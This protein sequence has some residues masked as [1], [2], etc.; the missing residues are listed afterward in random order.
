M[1]LG[2]TAM[3]KKSV[4]VII[5]TNGPG[6]LSTWVKPVVDN[7]SK[8]NKLSKK[9]NKYYLSLNLVL[10]PCPNSTGKEY[11][12]AKSWMKFETVTKAENF[13]KLIIRPSLYAKWPKNGIVVFLGGDQFWSVLLSK[14]LGYANITYSEWVARWPRWCDIIATMNENVKKRIPQKYRYKCEV[15]GD[16]MADFKNSK[17]ISSNTREKQWIALLPGSKKAKLSV[18]IPYFLEVADNIAKKDK[19]INL[20]IPMAPTT[21]TNDYLF[22]QSNE[23]PIAKKYSSKIKNIQEIQNSVFNYIIHTSKNTKIYLIKNHPCHKFLKKCDLAITTVGA[24]TA[25]LASLTIPMVVVL[26]TQHLNVMNSW[27]GIFGI[28][29]KISFINKL[30]T[31]IIKNWYLRN[32]KFF[33]WPNIKAKKLIVPERIG[34]ISPKEIAKEAIFLMNNKKYLKEQ[35]YNLSIQRGKTGA[36]R[37]LAHLILDS[38]KRVS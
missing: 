21:S 16:L 34:N 24:N 38:I 7:L 19:N 20:L 15:I 2:L 18:G 17:D 22:F 31:V 3:K 23:N 30:F 6:E 25:E 12:V 26:P 13:W 35:K 9:N 29:G 28:I 4:A 36:A 11:E 1:Y 33:A 14:R 10:V 8:I 37:K 5:I 32:K 27:D